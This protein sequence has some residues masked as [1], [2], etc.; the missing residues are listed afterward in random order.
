MG[1]PITVSIDFVNPR[2]KELGDS[3]HSQF[4]LGIASEVGHVCLLL[5]QVCNTHIFHD[6]SKVIGARQAEFG[7]V[8]FQSP[9]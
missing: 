2:V 5:L 9:I 3:Y 4:P 7:D 8:E 1:L 6:I